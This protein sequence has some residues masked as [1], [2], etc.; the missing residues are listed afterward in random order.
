V[1][2]AP[3]AAPRFSFWRFLLRAVP[4][5]AAIASTS[6]LAYFLLSERWQGQVQLQQQ[7]QQE[8]AQT[9]PQQP[10]AQTQVQQPPP[11]PQAQTQV[12]EPDP[13]VPDPLP[14]IPNGDKLIIL[15][16]SALIA[17]NQANATGNYTVLRDMAA[18][19]FQRANSPERL[20]QAFADLR[21]RNLDLS[22]VVLYQPKLYRQPEMNAKGMVRITGF[23]PTSPERVNFD[24]IFQPVQGRWRLYGIA[25]NTEPA[26]PAPAPAPAAEDSAK[27]A[28]KPTK[29]PVEAAKPAPQADIRDRLDTPPAPP[30]PAE[31][32]KQKSLFN[33]F[34]Q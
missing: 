30:P 7:P 1:Q 18:P 9:A 21:R 34:G 5:V 26:P 29:K 4:T 17:L 25:A 20:A 19:G 22:P 32:P 14:P 28:A 15:I 24:L 13:P 3:P 10:Q 16:N 12:Q 2:V 11:Q 27:S 23:L 31:K 6:V 8:V 33:P